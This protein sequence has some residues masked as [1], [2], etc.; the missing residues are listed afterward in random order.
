MA[1]IAK[2]GLEAGNWIG[3]G[4]S[5]LVPFCFAMQTLTLRRYRAVDMTPAICVGGVMAFVDSGLAGYIFQG[6]AALMCR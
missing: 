4:V 2:D 6:A 3:M 1:V 5:L